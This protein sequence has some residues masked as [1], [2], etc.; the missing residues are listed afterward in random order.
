MDVYSVVLLCVAGSNLFFLI[1]RPSHHQ[2]GEW[3]LMLASEV[4]LKRK[5]PAVLWIWLLQR[6]EGLCSVK[7]LSCE[8]LRP[9]DFLL[10]HAKRRHCRGVCLCNK[11]RMCR[12]L[13]WIRINARVVRW[14]EFA[15]PHHYR[16]RKDYDNIASISE[17]YKNE[18][19]VVAGK[20]MNETSI[21]WA[22][23]TWD[24][25]NLGRVVIEMYRKSGWIVCLRGTQGNIRSAMGF[26]VNKIFPPEEEE[27]E[28]SPIVWMEVDWS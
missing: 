6:E 14:R 1:P 22:L 2:E 9:S 4:V 7:G 27:A 26:A 25:W 16:Q 23:C 17:W 28:E 11:S 15:N 5:E 18:E 20:L 19:R 13:N 12:V 3:M 21:V 8:S 24:G 10:L